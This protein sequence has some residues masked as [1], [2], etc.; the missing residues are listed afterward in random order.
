MFF[1]KKSNKAFL[2][3]G[4]YMHFIFNLY[5]YDDFVVDIS[6]SH[7]P[8]VCC[9]LDIAGVFQ[10]KADTAAARKAFL[11]RIKYTMINQSMV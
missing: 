5:E 3:E 2:L 4:E 6:P 7:C 11:V 9:S 8:F 1:N 10:G